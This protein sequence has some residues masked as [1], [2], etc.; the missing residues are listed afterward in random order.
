M[1]FL[2]I[3]LF[4]LVAA[5]QSVGVGD[6]LDMGR[7]RSLRCEQRGYLN[8]RLKAERS[9]DTTTLRYIDGS[10]HA[11]ETIKEMVS[12]LKLAKSLVKSYE[13]WDFKIQLPSSAC[14]ASGDKAKFLECRAEKGIEIDLHAALSAHFPKED[15]E[16]YRLRF[17]S[18]HGS[19][20][21]VRVQDAK[22]KSHPALRMEWSFVEGSK[23]HRLA[24]DYRLHE[25]FSDAGVHSIVSDCI[26]DGVELLD[27]P[28]LPFSLGNEDEACFSTKSCMPG[29]HCL[30]GICRKKSPF[31]V[32]FSDADCAIADSC[33]KGVCKPKG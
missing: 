17:D 30:G 25:S 18:F 3:S 10:R 8:Y 26:T 6:A 20:E 29:E 22:G 15:F 2:V 14:V 7:F 9:K 5:S 21:K 13:S 31:D 19:L 24:V 32:C 28:D 23:T 11:I 4:T 16:D 33:V 12:Q 27:W 1:K